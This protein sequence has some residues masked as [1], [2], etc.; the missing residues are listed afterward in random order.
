MLAD[1]LGT[2][3]ITETIIGCG[4]R[5]HRVLGPGLLESA[6]VPCLEL[7]LRDAGLAV[8]REVPVPLVYR[9]VR[10]DAG[11]RVDLLVA[12]L[13]VVEVKACAATV[14]VHRAQLLTYLKLLQK[15][16]GL[17][18]NFNVP[19]LKNGITRVLNADLL[20]ETAAASTQQK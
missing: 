11:Y 8:V 18:I 1:P 13:V 15:P 2:N 17:I 5:F 19:L 16:A 20:R 10:L 9:S 12:N 7:E 3:R 4:I 14:P 6:Y